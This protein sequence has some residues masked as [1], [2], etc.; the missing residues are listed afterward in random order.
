MEKATDFIW[1]YLFARY[2]NSHQANMDLK[3]TFLSGT[4]SVSV[5]L[6]MIFLI[7][8]LFICCHVFPKTQ[9]FMRWTMKLWLNM[10]YLE[11]LVECHKIKNWLKTSYSAWYYTNYHHRSA[12]RVSSIIVHGNRAKH[13]QRWS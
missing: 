10:F 4:H 6:D 13:R 5:D 8:E 3:S 2:S 11:I 12:F 1:I 7:F 9:L